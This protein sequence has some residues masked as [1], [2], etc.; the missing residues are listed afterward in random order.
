LDP[1]S[2]NFATISSTSV[3]FNISSLFVFTT[4]L[5]KVSG[6]HL[7]RDG[8]GGGFST[9]TKFV[10]LSVC[11]VFKKAFFFVFLFTRVFSFRFSYICAVDNMHAINRGWVYTL[12]R[13]SLMNYV[14]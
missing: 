9:R 7:E 8:A 4:W 1:D 14:L 10:R 5:D 13:T 6:G 3:V 2:I 12:C 11:A